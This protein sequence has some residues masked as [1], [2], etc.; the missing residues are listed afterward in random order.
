MMKITNVMKYASP[1]ALLILATA[2]P[3]VMALD[4]RI[5]YTGRIT[6]ETCVVQPASN[7]QRIDMGQFSVA[8]FMK[9]GDVSP[10]KPFSITL[11]RCTANIRAAKVTFSGTLDS[12]DR[13][14]IALTAAADAA[15]GVGI[16][17]LDATGAKIVP[18]TQVR[19]PVGPGSAVLD[20]SL[21][22]RA[23]G[24]AVGAGKADAVVFFDVD[25]E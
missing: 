9:A 25:Y 7:S 23:S 6:P 4:T 1:R 12:R 8:D 20:Y 3:E 16:E 17:I 11:E 13:T 22:Y 19:H 15:K 24:A 5:Q 14:L 10:S 18:G 21:R 2:V